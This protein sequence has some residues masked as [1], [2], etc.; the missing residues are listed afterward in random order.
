MLFRDFDDNKRLGEF[1]EHQFMFFGLE[2]DLPENIDD[3]H[4]KELD[5]S[6]DEC[7]EHIG[8]SVSEMTDLREYYVIHQE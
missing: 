1:V 4:R 2:N 6:K 8:I 5:H 7:I 3:K